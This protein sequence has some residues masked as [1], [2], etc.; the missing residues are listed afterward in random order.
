MSPEHMF[1]SINVMASI[2]QETTA[3]TLRG[4]K[5]V[6][7][8]VHAVTL[9]ACGLARK[10]VLAILANISPQDD[11]IA[12]GDAHGSGRLHTTIHQKGTKPLLWWEAKKL[13]FRAALLRDWLLDAARLAWN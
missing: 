4:K 9:R 5:Q 12:R 11:R 10:Q 6:N 3:Y 8:R 7:T 1:Q 13:G 2:A